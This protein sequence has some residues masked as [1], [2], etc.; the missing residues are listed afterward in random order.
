MSVCSDMLEVILGPINIHP[1]SAS[2]P[3]M[4]TANTAAEETID[5][6]SEENLQSDVSIAC[7]AMSCSI[8]DSKASTANANTKT[9]NMSDKGNF[10]WLEIEDV[11]I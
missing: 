7:N 10:I 9:E 2:G 5:A 1:P 8:E 11:T 3:P 4:I 6:K